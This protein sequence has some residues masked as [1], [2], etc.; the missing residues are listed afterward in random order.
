MGLINGNYVAL[1]ALVVPKY[2]WVKVAEGTV[3]ERVSNII[4]DNVNGAHRNF[5]GVAFKYTAP[6]RVDK[7]KCNIFVQLLN[8]DRS[9]KNYPYVKYVTFS[10]QMM[11]AS[12]YSYINHGQLIADGSNGMFQ[13]FWYV[14]N[15]KPIGDHALQNMH[16]LHYN[17]SG[18]ASDELESNAIRIT[19]RTSVDAD[20]NTVGGFEEDTTYEIW[21]L[22]KEVS[23]L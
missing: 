9:A 12:S 15:G 17:F 19:C 13:G 21:G 20:G 3:S 18:A 11:D 7:Q 1:D 14:G 22:V 4:V 10:N 2:R 5:Y 6:K 16:P 8:M 23:D